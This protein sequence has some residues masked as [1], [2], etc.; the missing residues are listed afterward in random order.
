MVYYL[1]KVSNNKRCLTE[2]NNTK[3][4][5]CAGGNLVQEEKGKKLQKPARGLTPACLYK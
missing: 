3:N 5:R 1:S 4:M 2:G